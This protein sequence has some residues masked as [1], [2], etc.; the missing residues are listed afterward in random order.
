MVIPEWH[1]GWEK[2][3]DFTIWHHFVLGENGG[4]D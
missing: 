4:G 1:G 3:L 2:E